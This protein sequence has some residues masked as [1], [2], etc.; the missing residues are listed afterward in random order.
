MPDEDKSDSCFFKTC[1]PLCAAVY[2]VLA[3]LFLY[4]LMLVVANMIKLVVALGNALS[5]A[6][7][8]CLG[9]KWRTADPDNIHEEGEKQMDEG[10]KTT[11]EEMDL[12][13][14]LG[15]CV[16]ELV[17]ACLYIAASGGISE[18][19]VVFISALFSFGSALIGIGKGL[20]LCRKN[21]CQLT[22]FLYEEGSANKKEDP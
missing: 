1:Y 3:G 8:C 14:N 13:H 10:S 21:G 11:L 22:S 6:F 20:L 15:G 9:K 18:N 5:V 4:F 2:P 19:V 17:V 16:P 7:D 12:L